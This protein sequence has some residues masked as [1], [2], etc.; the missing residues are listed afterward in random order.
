[1]STGGMP[2]DHGGRDRSNASIT[3]GVYRLSPGTSLVVQWIKLH[4]LCGG[5]GFD[6][7]SRNKILHAM[8]CGQ[9]IKI[10]IKTNSKLP[11]ARGEGWTDSLL[12]T[13]EATNHAD[14]VILEFHPPAR[15]YISV[16][17]GRPVCAILLWH[18]QET[19][20]EAM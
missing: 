10:K 20:P 14:T 5:L 15:S 2:C 3:K 7:W 6:P 4:F 17:S 9:K 1:M 8:W 16:A 12:Q 19:N 13:L 11:E 18:I